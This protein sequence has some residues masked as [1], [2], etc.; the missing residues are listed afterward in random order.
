MSHYLLNCNCIPL[1]LLLVMLPSVPVFSSL[2]IYHSGQDNRE[3]V[4]TMEELP[5]ITDLTFESTNIC[6][7]SYAIDNDRIICKFTTL[8]PCCLPATLALF[9]P[10]YT[11]NTSS[12]MSLTIPVNSLPFPSPNKGTTLYLLNPLQDGRHWICSFSIQTGYLPDQ[13][14]IQACQILNCIFQNGY[15]YY[16]RNPC[17]TYFAPILF[18]YQITSLDSDAMDSPMLPENHTAF[19]YKILEITSNHPVKLL[20]PYQYQTESGQVWEFSMID[21]AG[22]GPC[23]ITFLLEDTDVL[24]YNLTNSENKEAFYAG[25]SHSHCR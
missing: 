6:S 3:S 9:S 19:N 25:K 1:I 24:L 23:A 5:I 7:S 4:P 15:Q 17:I 21:A 14:S 13:A 20:P 11:I 16:G 12:A 18:H 2:L 8:E 22:N 10:T